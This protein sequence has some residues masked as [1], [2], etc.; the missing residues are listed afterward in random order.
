MTHR[1]AIDGLRALAILPVVLYHAGLPG[2][3]SGFV[4]V[5][6]FFV[7]SGYL[8][9]G[10]LLQDLAA[11]RFSLVAFY[12]RRARRILPAL[13]VV[14]AACLPAA[15]FLLLPEARKEFAQSLIGVGTF[16][17]NLLFMRKSGYF[18]I[19]AELKPLLHTWSLAVEEQFYLLFP[20]LLLAAWRHARARLTLIIAALAL[21]SLGLAWQLGQ[22]DPHAA[23]YLLPTRAWELLLGAFAAALHQRCPHALAARDRVRDLLCAGGLL[24]ILLGL[25]LPAQAS[26]PAPAALLATGGTVL[27]LLFAND[28]SPVGRLLGLPPLVGIGL[29][30]Y[31]LYLWHQPLFAFARH[32]P[33]SP[34]QPPV[35]VLLGLL[36]VLLAWASWAWVEQPWRARRRFS[37]RQVFIAAALGTCGLLGLG[38]LGHLAQGFPRHGALPAHLAATLQPGPRQ[39]EC[40]NKPGMHQREDWLC[41]I[42]PDDGRPASF[43]VF[44]DSHS[45]ALLPAFDALAATGSERGAYSGLIGCPPVLG[46]HAPKGESDQDCHAFNQRVLAHVAA[47]PEIRRVVLV[48]RWTYYT[49]GGYGG[50]DYLLLGT[51][52]GGGAHLA[53]S[54]AALAAGFAHTVRTLR[55]LGRE[56]LVV[57]QVPQQLG[58]P[59]LA[60]R[61]A[62]NDDPASFASA[63]R[64]AAVARVLH[65]QMQAPVR[66]LLRQAAAGEARFITLD[67]ALCDETACTLGSPEAGFYYDADH[68]SPAGARHVAPRLNTLLFE[69]AR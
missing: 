53:E 39:S 64:S 46:V 9:T 37:R 13:F 51:T 63:L 49:N 22:R 17:S 50:K 12:E 36:A 42:G 1:R 48:G 19:A 43:L 60:Y 68:L 11:G 29:I 40:F 31:S 47:H 65:R 35:F 41:R 32:W 67:D 7:I 38:A 16:L 62:L 3:A 61:H 45:A 15:W 25:T 14:C 30:S 54:T 26:F 57:E 58:D 27:L 44:G 56:V 4:G 34:P 59:A 52:P 10:L 18:D 66:E 2:V 23:F 6:I 55:A 69:E 5:D 21:G 8:I 28:R 24:A 20:L 33:G